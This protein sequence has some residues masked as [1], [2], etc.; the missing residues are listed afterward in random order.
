MLKSIFTALAVVITL[1]LVAGASA[2][3]KDGYWEITTKAEMKGMQGK[4]HGATM[5]QCITKKDSDTKPQQK[6]VKGQECKVKE[7][8][9]TGDT[10][11]TLTECKTEEGGSTLINS[12][13]TFK[14]DS[15]DGNTDM[16]IKVKGQPDMQ[17]SS[18]MTGK[19]LGPCPEEKVKPAKK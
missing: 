18:S 15:F 13:M 10:I 4:T 14:G 3:I 6:P 16:T 2:E 17:M 5:K 11:T 19:Y 12:K 7:R 1:V 8:K 9:V